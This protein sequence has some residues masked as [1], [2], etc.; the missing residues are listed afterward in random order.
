VG[1][2][3]IKLALILTA[4]DPSIGGVLLAG[5]KGTGKSV[6]V[7]AFAEVLPEI[8]AVE[9]CVFNCNP[10]DPTNMC[11]SCRSQFSED[12]NLPNIRRRMRV[13][14]IPIGAT[15]DRVIGTMDSEK[16]MREGSKALQP[17]LLAEANQNVL[18]IDEVNLLPDHLVDAILDSA[19]SGWNFVER[20]GISISHPSRFILVGT[21]N[22]EEGSLRPQ[23]ADRFGIQAHAENIIN[24]KER[25]EVTKRNEEFARNP[26]AFCEKYRQQ[27]NELRK[28]IEDAR[29]LLS[30]V[31]VP[32][33][34]LESIAKVCTSLEVDGYRPDIVTLKASRALAA[35]NG[36]TVLQPTDVLT[37]SKLALSHRTRRSGL[38]SPPS[39]PEIHEA[40]ENTPLKK[41]ILSSTLGPW[42]SLYPIRKLK[43]LKINFLLKFVFLSLIMF[44]FLYFLFS[45]S[46]ELFFDL[47][48]TPSA[49]LSPVPVLAGAVFGALLAIAFAAFVLKP[50]KK[51]PIYIL[52]LSKITT[53][54][55]LDSEEVIVAE[56]DEA[57]RS[58]FEVKLNGDEKPFLD[59]GQNVFE[60]SS[61]FTE[62]HQF[63]KHQRQKDQRPRQGRQY[64]AGKRVK[65]VTSASRGRYVWHQLP[66][67]RPWDIALGPTIR[68]AAPYQST[69]KLEDLS[70]AIE[71]QDLRVKRREYRAP[72]SIILLVDMSFSMINSIS[73]L[74]RAIRSLHRSVYRRRDRVGLIV[75]KGTEAFTLQAPT[76]NLD[77]IVRKLLKVKASDFTPL[78]LGMLNAWKALKLEKLRN[79]DAIPML[80]IVSDGIANIALKQPLT[81]RQNAVF[82]S[83]AQSD[84]F[85]VAQRIRRDNIR[86]II[87]NTSHSSLELLA[88]GIETEPNKRSKPYT[89]T[90]FLMK[91][92]KT[93]KGSYYG[94]SLR[95]EE[96]KK[97][98]VEEKPQDWFYF[99]TP[100]K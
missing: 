94:L 10:E 11:E 92:S 53:K 50:S 82:V 81:G 55:M 68:A 34:I 42:R 52:D 58:P 46:L 99:E 20:E 85:D 59:R 32:Q 47:F 2:S 5:P 35:F 13:V 41:E 63:E 87:I 65:T 100:S 57:V 27:Q 6:A 83:E 95:K 8:A 25:M 30:Q 51:P 37:A 69:R 91:L 73:N 3:N 36:R 9:G 66:K 1:Q 64:I 67:V 80:I 56:S 90:E 40:W 23:I 7:R 26:L 96:E 76:T 17:G 43:K 98:I 15:E 28:K 45:S 33:N 19:S 16:A 54:Q 72:F 48:Q 89:P 93:T 84:A 74:S 70:I 39:S 44:L 38:M 79:K 49:S 12:L 24:P 88:A 31:S 86:T 14:Q 97:E 78:A 62:T 29:K 4:I 60:N 75:F 21:M 77:L 71:P 18:Y 22:P 61:E